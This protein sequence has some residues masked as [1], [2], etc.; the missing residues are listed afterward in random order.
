M[1]Y[2]RLIES[3]R[4]LIPPASTTERLARR[5]VLDDLLDSPALLKVAGTGTRLYQRSG[6]QTAMRATG[7]LR[8]APRLR[9]MDLDAAE[10]VGSL[11]DGDLPAFVPAVG[12][13]RYRVAFLRGCVA[14]QF[15]PQ[16]NRSTV[17]VLAANG[18]D[19]YTPPEQGAVAPCRTTAAT[20][21]P[22]WRW[23]DITSTYSSA[24]TL[25]SSSPT[26]PAVARR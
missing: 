4:S 14:S 20:G 8:L 16:T 22:P 5:F 11:V 24:L 2:G 19:V 12:L 23:R 7:A 17:A 1:Q 6:L 18:C 10:L 13:P 26:P 25:T 15:F 21:K 9:R 3:A